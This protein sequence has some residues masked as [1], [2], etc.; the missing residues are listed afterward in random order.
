MEQPSASFMIPTILACIFTDCT[1]RKWRKRDSTGQ[2]CRHEYTLVGSPRRCFSTP[3]GSLGSER[4]LFIPCIRAVKGFNITN[5]I[6]SSP[7]R[8]DQWRDSQSRT[9]AQLGCTPATLSIALN[10]FALRYDS[11]AS[12]IDVLCKVSVLLAAAP[13]LQVLLR[14]LWVEGPTERPISYLGH[15][16]V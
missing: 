10:M 16:W 11:L 4:G 12:I 14:T 5:Q 15:G 6:P 1:A 13:K 8:R 9:A 7:I 2:P 3:I